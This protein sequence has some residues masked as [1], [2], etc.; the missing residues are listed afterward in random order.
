MTPKCR[1]LVGRNPPINFEGG[2]LTLTPLILG[3]IYLVII[4]IC[5][6]VQ[7]I[8]IGGGGVGMAPL[9]LIQLFIYIEILE[10][11]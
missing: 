11:F 8:F 7:V 4:Y 9:K 5:K 1:G 6:Y 3:Y 2:R 10:S